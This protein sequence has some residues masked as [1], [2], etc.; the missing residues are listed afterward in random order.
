VIGVLKKHENSLILSCLFFAFYLLV[1]HTLDQYSPDRYTAYIFAC[2]ALLVLNIWL[3]ISSFIDYR[4][5]QLN[6]CFFYF[7]SLVFLIGLFL[8]FDWL[9]EINIFASHRKFKSRALFILFS[10]IFII[11]G[12]KSIKAIFWDGF[13]CSLIKKEKIKLYQIISAILYI[14][15]IILLINPLRLY[16]TSP[17]E[18]GIRF[19]DLLIACMINFAAVLIILFSISVVV[20]GFLKKQLVIFFYFLAAFIF[21]YTFIFSGNFGALDSFILG[22]AENLY[23]KF[24]RNIIEVLFI[25]LLWH[26]ILFLI[27][28]GKIKVLAISFFILSSIASI[29]F[30]FILVKG[31]VLHPA[32]TESAINEDLLPAYNSRMMGYTRKENNIIVILLD[33]MTGGYVP[34]LLEEIP[35]VMEKYKGFIWYPNTLTIGN[36]TT[37]S[38]AAMYGGWSYSPVEVNKNN[39]KK[40]L[41]EIITESYEVLPNLLKEKNYVTSYTNPE[42]Y[43]SQNGDVDLLRRK[44]I[45]AGFNR[46]YIPYWNYRNR[47]NQEDDLDNSNSVLVR[48]LTVVSIFKTAP[49]LLKPIIYDDGDWLIIGRDEIKNDGYRH[50]LEHWAFLDL[51]KD[52]SNVNEN[53]N[54]F[55]YFHNNITHPPFAMSKEGV[56]LKNEFPD[57]SG[58]SRY[59]DNSYYSYKAAFEAISRWMDWLKKEGI[60]DNTMIILVSDHGSEN[61]KNPMIPADFKIEEASQKYLR[62]AN[63]LLMVKKFNSNE[64]FTTDWRFMSNADVPALICNT[65][66][67]YN[68]DIGEDP[69]EGDPRENRVLDTVHT[70]AWKWEQLVRRTQFDIFWHYKVKNNLF[71]D[72]NWERIK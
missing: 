49:F 27:N 7:A 22:N 68:K 48:L 19:F 55:K 2:A 44:G 71:D 4:N 16:A 46:D 45:I 61:I 34:R 57:P 42:F 66:G 24:Y 28:R 69:T 51:M 54:T 72:K 47:E 8:P 9:L 65:V 64:D 33:G 56:L 53:N 31:K 59:G 35:G 17:D 23:G 62:S 52:I 20:P 36:H 58:G 67:I 70:H 40:T 11:V 1:F 39:S 13:F 30:L 25:I 60:Y 38:M 50:A 6:K 10:Y 18:L 63:A 3:F 26:L 14:S 15:L 41:L 43:I 32:Q 5:K 29:E 12:Y 37:T 21:F